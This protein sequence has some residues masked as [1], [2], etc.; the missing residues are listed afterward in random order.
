MHRLKGSKKETCKQFLML[1][2]YSL[3]EKT[4]INLLKEVGWDMNNAMDYYF[5][6]Q[7]KLVG[8]NNQAS[9]SR[10]AVKDIFK[11]Y[12]KVSTKYNQKTTLCFKSFISF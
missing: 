5:R 4:A 12:R 2:D 7:H 9:Q 3:D 8:S 11:K 6:N 1:V 10:N